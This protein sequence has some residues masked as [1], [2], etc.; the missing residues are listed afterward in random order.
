MSPT[1][2]LMATPTVRVAMRKQPLRGRRL[3]MA[4]LVRTAMV[5]VIGDMLKLRT[6]DLKESELRTIFAEAEV[7]VVVTRTLV[8]GVSS[9]LEMF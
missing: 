7:A 8:R 6:E 1:C 5:V 9:E 2:L 3:T 4:V